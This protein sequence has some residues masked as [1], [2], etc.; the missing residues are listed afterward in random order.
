MKVLVG[1]I[2]KQLL[3]SH[4]FCTAKHIPYLAFI[5]RTKNAVVENSNNNHRYS[6]GNT[7][8]SNIQKY[9]FAEAT[10]FHRSTNNYKPKIPV[11][12]FLDA[13]QLD[14][15]ESTTTF[16]IKY[17]PFCPKP[18]NEEKTNLYVL[19][20]HKEYGYYKCFRCSASGSWLQF[21]EKILG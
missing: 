11:Y 19:N 15:A 20:V 12:Q 21:R 9:F 14:Y 1:I 3:L 7:M 8:L 2:G 5:K 17:C 4:G 13:H 16:K 18:H 6:H 10:Y